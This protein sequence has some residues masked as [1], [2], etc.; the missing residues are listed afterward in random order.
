MTHEARLVLFTSAIRRA[1]AVLARHFEPGGLSAADVI[2]R[3]L[4]IL[5]DEQLRKAMKHEHRS[6]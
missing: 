3:L 1:R 6:E 5:E 4:P 2:N